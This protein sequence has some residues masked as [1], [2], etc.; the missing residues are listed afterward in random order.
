MTTIIAAL[1]ATGLEY[2]E[3][4]SDIPMLH[5]GGWYD[6]YAPGTIQSFVELSRLKSAP[7]MLLMG[8]W[9]HGG[10]SRSTAGDIEFGAEAA[11][12]DFSREF[13]LRWFDRQLR[14][15][16]DNDLFEDDARLAGRAPGAV[17]IFVMGGGDGRTDENGRLFHG[18]GVAHGGLV[19]ARG[20]RDDAVPPPRG[21]RP[22]A[23]TPGRRRG[24]HR[25]YLRPGAPGADDRRRLL[26]RPQAGR[27]R[28]A[29]AHLPIAAGR[30]RER[31]LRLRGWTA[32]APPTAPMSSCSRPTRCPKT[33]R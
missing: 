23:R 12:E 13:H 10:N 26:G 25:V 5:V 30:I 31:L 19:A 14:G 18:G 21:G 15:Q 4:T 27:L 2:Y 7:M 6:S 3:Q 29:R 17:T 8:P 11:I 32:A 28:S 22:H 16:R 1:G 20:N 9:T 33:S 24:I